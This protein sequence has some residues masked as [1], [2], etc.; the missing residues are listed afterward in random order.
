M[1]YDVTCLPAAS[2]QIYKADSQNSPFYLDEVILS[3]YF[4]GYYAV[5]TIPAPGS[6]SFWSE[7]AWISEHLPPPALCILCHELSLSLIIQEAA[8]AP[9]ALRSVSI[10]TSGDKHWIQIPGKPAWFNAILALCKTQSPC[11]LCSGGSQTEEINS[12]VF[13][14]TDAE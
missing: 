7:A 3:L 12:S 2:I 4:Y 9:W 10:P 5:C 14:T 8:S 6:H 13:S 11:N 1:L